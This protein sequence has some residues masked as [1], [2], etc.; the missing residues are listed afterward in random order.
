MHIARAVEE[1]VDRPRFGGRGSYGV[2]RQHVERAGSAAREGAEGREVEV[3]RD[4][5]RALTD[6]QFRRCPADALP[7]RRDEGALAL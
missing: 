4:D 1:D 3:G 5:L 6:E 2:G 7:R